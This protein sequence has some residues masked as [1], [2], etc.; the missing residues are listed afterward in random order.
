MQAEAFVPGHITGFFEVFK[1]DD[2]LHTGSRGA[3]VVLSKGS[4]TRVKLE[5]GG[6]ATRVYVNG[7]SCQ[8]P[9]TRSVVERMLREAGEQ[10]RVR[11]DHFL[12]LPMRY[13]F[14]M[15]GAGALGTALAMNAA[16]SLG[17]GSVACGRIA[18]EAE[19]VNGT[20]LGDVIAELTGGL[21]LRT[22][23]GAPGIGRVEKIVPDLG[24]VVFLVGEEMETKQ[25]LQDREAIERI[26]SAGRKSYETFCRDKTP[27]RFLRASWSFARASGLVNEKI[28][29]AAKTLAKHGV[30]SSMAMLGNALFTLTEDPSHVL[31]VLD[32]PCL[33]AGIDRE[34]ARI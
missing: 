10:Y 23:P 22:H 32:Y 2:P 17:L 20:G 3:G 29:L 9:V 16:L 27:E 25:V 33:T 7:A 8:C 15:S 14:G 12:D 28:Y 6:T 13:G 19:V 1:A 26:N 30:S 4:R 31:G 24:V 34:G 18:H 21:V 11:V 5:D